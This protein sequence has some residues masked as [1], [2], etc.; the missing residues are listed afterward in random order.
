MSSSSSFSSSFYFTESTSSMSCKSSA[1][2]A[3]SRE[4]DGTSEEASGSGV[5]GDLIDATSRLVAELAEDN[6]PRRV[7][8][9]WAS[10]QVTCHFSKYRW[11]LMVKSYAVAYRIFANS[12]FR[13]EHSLW[14]SVRP[15][16]IYVMGGKVIVHTSSSCMCANSQI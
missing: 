7:G 13:M 4:S 3:D 16:S 12:I 2:S 10:T 11:Y 15:L 1:H 8:Y 6:L 5:R 9:E 14:S